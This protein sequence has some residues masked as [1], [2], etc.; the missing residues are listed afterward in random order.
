MSKIMGNLPP[1]RPCHQIYDAITNYC[2]LVTGGSEA[3][4]VIIVIF[5]C[6]NYNELLFLEDLQETRLLVTTKSNTAFIL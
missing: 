6:K 1:L 5:W 4:E 2:S 3:S